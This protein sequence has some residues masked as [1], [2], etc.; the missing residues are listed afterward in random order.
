MTF[1]L[2]RLLGDQYFL[3][4]S[5]RISAFFEPSALDPANPKKLVVPK[6]QSINKIGHALCQLDPVF[7]EQTLA[8]EGLQDLARDLAV[9]K[10][11][12]GK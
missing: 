12:L 1:R 2:I 10:D 11:P 3:D 5:S 7:K 6:Q 9:H 8:N 4:S